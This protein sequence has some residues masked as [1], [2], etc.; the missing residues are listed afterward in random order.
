M[1]FRIFI[2]K[3]PDAHDRGCSI[4]G[5]KVPLTS[6]APVKAKP[7]V[8]SYDDSSAFGPYADYWKIPVCLVL[9]ARPGLAPHFRGVDFMLVPTDWC[10]VDPVR[11]WHDLDTSI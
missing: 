7:D 6:Y 11:S 9:L 10:A 3:D 4:A 2:F 5:I 1:K 8:Q